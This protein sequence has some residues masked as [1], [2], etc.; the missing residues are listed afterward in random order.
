MNEEKISLVTG[1]KVNMKKD[2]ILSIYT[3]TYN[4]K[5]IIVDKIQK[6]LSVP[7]QEFEILVLDD[8]SSDGTY[9]ALKKIDDVRLHVMQNMNRQGILENGAMPNWYMLLEK[10]SGIFAFHLNDRDMIA[11]DEIEKLI[12]FLKEHME[13]SGGVCSNKF[14]IRKYVSPEEAFYN[15]PYRGS[16]PTGIIFNLK[17][18]QKIKNRKEIFTKEISYIHP[19]DLILGILSQEGYMFQYKKI[20]KLAESESFANNKSFLYQKGDIK[21]SWFSPAERIKEFELFI[22]SLQKLTF[23]SAVKKKKVQQIAKCYLYFCTFNYAYYISD[24]GQAMHYGI[25]RTQLSK[26]ELVSEKKKFISKSY[27]ILKRNNLAVSKYVY[28][29][30][31]MVYFWII[32]MIRP[33]WVK[34][35]KLMK[36]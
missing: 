8:K 14:S 23:E 5:D 18:Y 24:V 11:V 7:S 20:W 34:L 21:S 27:A 9:E 26:K 12:I 36:W 29:I 32:Y 6:L 10:C 35:K 31:L 30:K 16:H 4:R 15:I 1:N 28:K 2:I 22:Y 25:E 33:I 19:H 3:A 13:Y 17:K